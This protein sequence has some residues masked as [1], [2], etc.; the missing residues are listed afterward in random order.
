MR[1]CYQFQLTC[2]VL[3][4]HLHTANKYQ[5]QRF[6]FHHNAKN[7]A[8]PTHEYPAITSYNINPFSKF[9]T[10][11]SVLLHHHHILVSSHLCLIAF[12]LQW[13]WYSRFFSLFFC[14]SLHDPFRD[15]PQEPRVNLSTNCYPNSLLQNY[16]T[17]V[18]NLLPKF[19]IK[20]LPLVL[21][22][23]RHL[24]QLERNTNSH[25]KSLLPTLPSKHPIGQT[26]SFIHSMF[27]PDLKRKRMDW[28]GMQLSHLDAA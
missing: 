22:Y 6:S 20:N 26:E 2:R 18:G 25:E 5:Y 3:N 11:N 16:F 13:L 7:P 12:E 28:T 21:L 14:F 23:Q 4:H 9:S 19:H 1:N 8:A 27:Y 17:A 10:G 15:P 24:Q